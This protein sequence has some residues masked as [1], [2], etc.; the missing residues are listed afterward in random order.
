MRFFTNKKTM[1]AVF[2]FC[3]CSTAFSQTKEVNIEAGKLSEKI[4]EEEQTT[5]TSL[6]ITGKINGSDI[7]LLRKMAGKAYETNVKTNG[8]LSSLDL[9]QAQI[10]KGGSNYYVIKRGL[11]S[12]YYQPTEDNVIAPYMFTG[13]TTLTTLKLPTNITKIEMF[14]F[15]GCSNLTECAIPES[16]TTIG[17]N[18]F[19]QCSKLKTIAIPR[20]VTSLGVAA[21]K[22]CDA[23]TNV[24]FAQGIQLEKIGKE[25]F[26]N[27]SSLT[28]ITLPKSVTEIEERAFYENYSLA[29]I[30]FPSGLTS[31]GV[32]AFENCLALTTLSKF[33]S[34]LENIEDKAFLNTSVTAFTVSSASDNYTSEDGILYDVDKVSLVLYPAGR[35][36]ETLNIPETVSS[37]AK[38]AFAYAKNL[39]SIELPSGLTN[40]NDS[41][42][43]FSKLTSVTTWGSNLAISKHAF[44]NCLN[45][46]TVDFKGAI[47]SIGDGAFQNDKK[48][49]TVKFVGT[50]IP[51]FG[52]YVFTPKIVELKIYVPSGYVDKYKEKIGKKPAVLGSKYQVLGDTTD[53]VLN[54]SFDGNV[55]E[56][57]RYNVDGTKVTTHTK[58]LN[59]IKLSDGSVIKTFEK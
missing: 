14:A 16:V 30:T 36:S 43:V 18:A 54:P 12:K 7:Q 34:S 57:A 59:I 25:V 32:S 26:S 21:F 23:V 31:I 19:A 39:K 17:D 44:S 48:L 45:L 11:S 8:K 38:Y 58:G 42:F 10:V 56:T 5:L 51:D 35:V 41:A 52:K 40:I 37:I 20:A 29:S 15:A 3:L 13:L 55:F 22:G 9:S 53:G 46:T 49:S 47:A 2:C 27:N 24:T 1:L 33:P 50:S 4:T 6:K 28:T